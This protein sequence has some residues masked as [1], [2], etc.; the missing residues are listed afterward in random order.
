MSKEETV[1]VRPPQVELL[2]SRM[3]RNNISE[4]T[5]F[6]VR[7]DINCVVVVVHFSFTT[8]CS[9]TCFNLHTDRDSFVTGGVIDDF[10][11]KKINISDPKKVGADVYTR[12]VEYMV[13]CE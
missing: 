10:L 13:G 1:A 6:Q 11:K 2:R 7:I 12:F 8:I 9:R 5:L 4:I 3:A